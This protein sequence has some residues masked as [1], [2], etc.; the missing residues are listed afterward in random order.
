MPSR[1]H[2]FLLGS[3]ACSD[4]YDPAYQRMIKELQGISV[5]YQKMQGLGDV[6]V[7][8]HETDPTSFHIGWVMG[9]V[10]YGW[11]TTG[12]DRSNQDFVT[13][14]EYNRDILV[15]LIGNMLALPNLP[16]APRRALERS[17]ADL[18]A[19]IKPQ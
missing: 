6:F 1:V 12:G 18:I 2:Q 16:E 13:S 17:K 15:L 19:W 9:P 5:L 11:V 7:V 4:Y 10:T 14:Q 8:P 3:S